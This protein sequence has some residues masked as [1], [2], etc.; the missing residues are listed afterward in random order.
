MKINMVNNFIPDKQPIF[1]SEE[2]IKPDEIELVTRRKIK[3][4]FDIHQELNNRT[5]I[6]PLPP[7]GHIVKGSILS[8]PQYFMDDVKTDVKALIAAA[9]GDANDHQLG[10]L[11]DLGMKLGGLAI[12]SYLFSMKKSPVT[13]AMEFVGFGSFFASMALW[14]KIALDIP[15]RLIHG[16]SPF[17]M[18]EDS[19]GR[20]KRFFTDNQFIPFDML[21]GKNINSEKQEYMRQVALQN[22][23][24]WMVTAGFATPVMSS[25]IC[26][27]LQPYVENLQSYFMNKKVDNILVNFASESKKFKSDDITK[28]VDTVISLNSGKPV[29]KEVIEELSDALVTQLDPNV[30]IGVKRDLQR[31]FP[32]GR[33]KITETH[34]KTITDTISTILK[35]AGGD[36]ILPQNL[37]M[38]IPTQEQVNELFRRKNYFNKTLNERDITYDIIPQITYL[39]EENIKTLKE[40]GAPLSSP[41]KKRLVT[42]LLEQPRDA[43]IKGLQEILKERPANILDDN[44]IKILKGFAKEIT[45]FCAENTALNVYS[46]SK[47][48]QAPNTAKAKYWNDVVSSLIDVL[49]ITPKEIEDTRYDRTLVGE[50]FNKKVW[51][52]ATASPEEYRKFV[53]SIAS[54]LSQIEKHVK[55]DDMTG[56]YISQVE[57]SMNAAA[58]RFRTFEPSFSFENTARKVA[59]INGKE[60][61]TLIGIT[62]TFVEDNLSNLKSTFAAVL[63]KVNTFRTIYRN[64]DFKFLGEDYEKIPREIKEELTGIIEYLTTEGR[65]ADYSVKFEFLRNLHPNTEDKGSVSFKSDG[66]VDYKFYNKEKL[67]KTGIFIQSDIP[68]FKRVMKTLFEVPVN[69]ETTAA[70]ADY[71]SVKKMLEDYRNNMASAVGNLYNFMFPDHVVNDRWNG[72]GQRI[73]SNATP[74]YRSN[75]VGAALDEV[76]ANCCKEAYN[77][78]KW[79]KMFGGFGAGLLGF[80]V[81]SQF[82]FGHGAGNDVKKEKA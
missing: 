78:R 27:R 45:G 58:A 82:F 51:A 11:N 68:F 38:I 16:F 23:T 17:M 80:T 75:A 49:K 54:K 63:N 32:S 46:Y 79:L 18:Y 1:A 8:A 39:V 15:A 26:N 53:G 60:K 2:Q 52:F 65:I 35:R 76:I 21:E 34:T 37:S 22:N 43:R 70:L 4:A 14:P 19:Q 25:L 73:Y 9:K 67:A 61:G 7:K 47:L 71:S 77:T 69:S 31:L 48:A 10:K 40:S 55:P 30:R 50:L 66:M 41:L 42:A 29:T 57:T 12:A 3:P 20:R 81:L 64:P 36:R 59:G 28:S 56:K 13:K 33:Y 6:K 62:K 72:N 44:S 5:F 24:M 74:K